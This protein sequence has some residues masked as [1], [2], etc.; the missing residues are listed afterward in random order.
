MASVLKTVD[1]RLQLQPD[2]PIDHTPTVGGAKGL[3]A[4]IA[5]ELLLAATNDSCLRLKSC[6]GTKCGVAFHDASRNQARVRHDA[7]VCG[8]APNLRASR[9]RWRR[10]G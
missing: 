4:L 8:N 9:T 10:D 1:I 6:A 5:I 7:M 3:A 2:D